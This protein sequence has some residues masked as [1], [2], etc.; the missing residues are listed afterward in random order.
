[1]AQSGSIPAR[2]DR[3]HPLALACELS[4]ADGVYATVDGMQPAGGD[5]MPDRLQGVSEIDELE[6]S[7]DAVL[8]GGEFPRPTRPL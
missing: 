1:M 6:E 4:P 2:E 7:D 5:P 8:N 3:S